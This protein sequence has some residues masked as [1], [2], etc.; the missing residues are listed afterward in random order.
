MSE[1]IDKLSKITDRQIEN[2]GYE[3]YINHGDYYLAVQP[4]TFGKGRII[5]AEGALTGIVNAW[6][7]EQLIDAI[8]AMYHWDVTGCDEPVGWIRNPIDG[9]R[10]ENGDPNKE[11]VR[12]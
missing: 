1:T 5:I 4:M 11:T 3:I 10:R 6:C 9:R 8:I 12:L 2:D 7:Y